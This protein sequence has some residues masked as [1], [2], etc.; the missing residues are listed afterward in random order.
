MTLFQFF[1]ARSLRPRRLCGEYWST[2]LP[3]R[4]GERRGGAEIS[5][6]PPVNPRASRI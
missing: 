4:R 2:T 1:S 6:T 3:R 5:R